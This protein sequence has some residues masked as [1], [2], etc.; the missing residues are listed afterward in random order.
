MHFRFILNRHL[1]KTDAGIGTPDNAKGDTDAKSVFF[2]SCHRTAIRSR[3][4]VVLAG[5]PKGRPVP[6]CAGS[7]NP[8]SATAI[9]IGTSR[10][11]S[12]N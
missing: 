12:L 7:S 1:S 2:V 9:E 5:L 4:M 11:S 8:V 6:F 10:G 3:S